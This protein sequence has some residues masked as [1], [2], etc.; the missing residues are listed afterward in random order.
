VSSGTS[1]P[2]LWNRL[3]I[4]D[5]KQFEIKLE[6]QPSAHEAKSKYLVEMY[7][8]LPQSLHVHAETYTRSQFYSDIHNYVRLK[9][10]VVE[11]EELLAREESPLV[12]LERR[13]ERGQI[14]PTSDLVYQSKLL[15][16]TFRAG[17]RRILGK[18]TEHATLVAKSTGAPDGGQ[19]EAQLRAHVFC[20]VKVLARFRA[21]NK[22]L[23]VR[24]PQLEEKTQV[25]LRLVD[26]YMSLSTEQFFR[27]TVAEMERLPKG[28][29]YG[30][31]RKLLIAEILREER[32]R[33]E[34]RLRSVLSPTGD[35]EEYMHRVGF[36]KKFCMNILFLSAR[37]DLRRQGWE[38]VTF[39]AAAGVAMLFATVVAV[40][41]QAR[42]PQASLNFV[43]II[44]VGYMMKDRIKEGLRRI[45]AS[46][47][48]RHLFD[49]S[50]SIVDPVTQDRVGMCYE[51]M[52]WGPPINVPEEILQ[53][54]KQDD[55]VTVSQGELT[56]YIIRYQKEIVLESAQLPKMMSGIS[57]VTDI[58]R[59]NVD[60][61][62]RDMDDPEHAIE[63]VDTEDLTIGRVRGA[64]SYQMDVAF[65]FTV[66]DQEQKRS[67][68]Q[69]VRL[70]LDRNGLKRMLRL[71][72]P[73]SQVSPPPEKRS[74][75]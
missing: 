11:L 22:R 23:L 24:F 49:R 6:Y 7:M 13:L 42:F 53:L 51:K 58:I 55:F 1:E 43:L 18:V 16:C 65:R 28:G 37:R 3:D 27:R 52:D 69:L 54:R 68:L 9:T 71:S 59:I 66:L 41:A 26:E 36:L 60:R 44:V 12:K 48:A 62:L 64:K 17:L 10:P 14:Q 50:V 31:L 47:A 46:L 57:G 67:S 25:S 32:Y 29:I 70:V 61:F 72:S 4:H 40:W 39:A 45:F 73:E 30:E 56:E 33:R 63:Y 34:N 15:S 19:L 2:L 8:F 35:N 5:R 74:V 75:A 20:G 38:E 21:W